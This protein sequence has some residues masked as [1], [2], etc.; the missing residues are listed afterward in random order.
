[1]KKRSLPWAGYAPLRAG[2]IHT[3]CPR[4]H[5]KLSNA[6]RNNYDPPR[7]ELVH[8]FCE[9]CGAGGKDAPEWFLDG[10]GKEIP[11]EEIESHIERIVDAKAEARER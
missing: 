4:C 11:W 1:M 7:A 8:T 9:R 5:R 6:P 3:W 2:R 10:D